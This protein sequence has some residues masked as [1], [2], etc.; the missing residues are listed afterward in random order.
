MNTLL[1]WCGRGGSG[2]GVGK[3]SLWTRTWR[4]SIITGP[5]LGQRQVKNGC[6]TFARVVKGID[7]VRHSEDHRWTATDGTFIFF[8][9]SPEKMPIEDEEFACD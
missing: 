5:A 3:A 9:R 1:L 6:Q 2:D 7:A 8:R 4:M